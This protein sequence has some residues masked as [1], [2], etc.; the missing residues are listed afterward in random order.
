L[1]FLKYNFREAYEL[2]CLGVTESDWK[3]FGMEALE[4]FEFEVAKKAFHRIRD[5]R[6]L[7]LINEIEVMIN[8]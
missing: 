8:T 1:I 6:S 3:I 2:A 5:S 7:V 4:N